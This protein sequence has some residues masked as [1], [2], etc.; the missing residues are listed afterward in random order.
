MDDKDEF[1]LEEN[2]VTNVD[3]IIELAEVEK[4]KFSNRA[5]GS[6]H[7]FLSS[8]YGPSKLYTLFNADMSQK[9][10]DTIIKTIDPKHLEIFPD[11]IIINRYDPG[12]FLVRHKDMAGRYW[13]FQLIFLRT[14][15]PHLMI[16]N[17]KYP[18]GKLIE[19]KPGA[20]FHMPLSLEHEVTLIE[21]NEK[22]KYS[23]VMAWSL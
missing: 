7:Q 12:S 3:E 8:K 23:L 6:E 1:W 22:P 9:L 20:L 2:Y 21:E 18:E 10:N 13:K 15:K 4:D 16:Y 11:H 5:A 17:K 14:D 19:E